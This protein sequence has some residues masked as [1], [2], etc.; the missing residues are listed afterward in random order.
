V[1]V[2]DDKTKPDLLQRALGAGAVASIPVPFNDA[3]FRSIPFTVTG[4]LHGRAVS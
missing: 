1:I 4:V 3:K 2:L